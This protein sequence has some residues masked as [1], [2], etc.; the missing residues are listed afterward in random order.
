MTGYAAIWRTREEFC[1]VWNS[2]RQVNLAD[3][4]LKAGSL[5]KPN[6]LVVDEAVLDVV[7]LVDVLH[8][9]LTLVLDKMLDNNISVRISRR[10]TLDENLGLVEVEGRASVLLEYRDR[11]AA[12]TLV[13]LE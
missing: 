12:L 13:R 2:A 1:T 3:S 11:G 4:V 10:D 8:N 6:E 9:C 7:E 5:A